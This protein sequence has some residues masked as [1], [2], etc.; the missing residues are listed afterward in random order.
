MVSVAFPNV[1]RDIDLVATLVQ[2][3]FDLCVVRWLC[4]G[5]Q[6][7]AFGERTVHAHEPHRYAEKQIVPGRSV[8]RPIESQEPAPLE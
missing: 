1:L 6:R 4:Y 5:G 3:R 2:K 8:E 7:L